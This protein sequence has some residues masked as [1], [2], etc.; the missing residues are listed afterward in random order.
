[1]L[2][3]CF[4]HSQNVTK[5]IALWYVQKLIF[6]SQLD[7]YIMYFDKMNVHKGWQKHVWQVTYRH[8]DNLVYSGLDAE[9]LFVISLNCDFITQCF[10]CTPPILVQ[11]RKKREMVRSGL[12]WE[13]KDVYILVMKKVQSKECLCHCVVQFVIALDLH[14]YKFSC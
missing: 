1:M 9:F 8:N 2:Q 6:I 12:G 5:F 13:E 3:K 11:H 7:F 4:A 10:S 14:N